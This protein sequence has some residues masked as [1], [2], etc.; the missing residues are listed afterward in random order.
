MAIGQRVIFAETLAEGR[1]VF[2][3]D[4]DMRCCQWRSC[5]TCPPSL[6]ATQFRGARHEQI[7]FIPQD[8]TNCPLETYIARTNRR[9]LGGAA[10]P[11]MQPARL[12]PNASRS[13]CR[14][15]LHRR[16]KMACAMRGENMAEMMR[17]LLNREFP[18]LPDE[19][20]SRGERKP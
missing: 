12:P 17:R 7:H 5:I 2:D 3:H 14:S 18:D 1:T 16:I 6:S 4:P 8:Q 20:L 19:E 15:N 10:Y 13:M 11:M 9:R